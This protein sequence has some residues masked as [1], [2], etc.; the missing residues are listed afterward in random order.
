[1][2]YIVSALL[3]LSLTGCIENGEDLTNKSTTKTIC[4][5][6]IK[7]WMIYPNSNSQSLALFISAETLQPVKCYE[8]TR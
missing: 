5:G 7:Y 2:K 6:G 3:L 4:L 8:S 1:M